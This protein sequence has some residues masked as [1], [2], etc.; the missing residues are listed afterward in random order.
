MAFDEK[1]KQ[2]AIKLGHQLRDNPWFSSVGIGEEQGHPTLI[3]YLVRE[4][5]KDQK[6]LPASWEGI[7]VRT[8]KIGKVIPAK[9]STD[10]DLAASERSFTP[11]RSKFTES[12]VED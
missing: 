10:R 2:A 5:G 4:P 8:Q 3:V 9:P 6:L 7:P 12:I 1:T 11:S